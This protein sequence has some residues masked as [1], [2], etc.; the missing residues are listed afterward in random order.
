MLVTRIYGGLGNQMFQYAAGKSISIARSEELMLD[1]SSYGIDGGENL[2]GRAL[3]ILD[4]KLEI[5]PEDPIKTFQFRYPSGLPSRIRSYFD[6][7]ILNKYF[8]GWHP[9]LYEDSK[10]NYLD[11]YFQ[12][13]NYAEII[14]ERINQSFKLKPEF[15]IEVSVLRKLFQRDEFIAIHVRRGDYFCNPEVQR[16]HGI[17]TPDYYEKGIKYL[18]RR[19]PD[20]QFALFSDDVDWAR[21]NI[22]GAESFFSVSQYAKENG[23][24]LRASQELSLMSECKHFL[25]S[26]S[27]YSWW[28]QYLSHNQKKCVVSPSLWNRNPRSRN[29]D[30]ID[31][32][33]HKI[34]IN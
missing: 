5:L 14:F 19:F 26:N 2:I 17:C 28:G 27:T 12:S 16:W 3:D 21:A 11:G 4:F 22:R 8:Y 34:L 23:V 18:K 7:K 20:F 1:T 10:L 31:S 15:E 30:L 13:K 9:E 25:I 24:E 6:K 33:W 32:T 29:I